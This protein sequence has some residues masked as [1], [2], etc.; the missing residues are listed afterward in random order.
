MDSLHKQKGLNLIELMIAMLLG[1][2]VVGVTIGILVSA[3]KSSSDTIKMTRLNQEMQAIMT[4]I[5]RDIRRAG[6]W[7]DNTATVNPYEPSVASGASDTITFAYDANSNGA[8]EATE[9]ISFRKN[10]NTIQI[11]QSAGGVWTNLSD[12]D[13]VNF[14]D[15]NGVAGQTFVIEADNTGSAVLRTVTINLQAELAEDSTVTR[16]VSENIRIRNDEIN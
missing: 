12:P 3:I 4:L 10:A 8:S 16:S 6:Y 11:R 2:I 5:S 9:T 13:V 1:L 7:G 15:F 14:V